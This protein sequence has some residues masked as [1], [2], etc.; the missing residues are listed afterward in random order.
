MKNDLEIQKNVIDEIQWDPQLSNIASRIEV[1]VT[2]EVVKLSG[3]VSHY[4]QKIAAE[5]A[6][7]RV[8]DVKVVVMDI[9]VGEKFPPKEIT[10]S[11]IGEAVRTALR[12]HSAVN[13]DL[14]NIKVENGFVYLEGTVDW[15]YE[16]KAA[17][18]SVEKLQGVKGVIN[19]VKIKDTKV[20]PSEIK[21]KIKS[22]FHR[23]ASLDAS[24]VNVLAIDGTVILSG[25]VRSWAERRDAE[26]V[27]WSMP[28]VTNVEN[29]L[30]IQEIY[31]GD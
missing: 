3:N 10:D 11:Q 31:V 17:E 8:R 15:D 13:E 14:I 12:W 29:N 23:H 26:D 1:T 24:K 2:N 22:T 27:V 20:E 9:E 6:A 7:K 18:N 21:K 4:A 25:A 16:R 30:E 28:G 19:D 5:Q